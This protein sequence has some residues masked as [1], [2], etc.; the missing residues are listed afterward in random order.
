MQRKLSNGHADRVFLLLAMS[1]PLIGDELRLR[2]ARWVVAYEKKMG[3]RS[4]KEMAKELDIKP[5]Q[6]TNILNHER[7]YE[8]TGKIPT[9]GLDTFIRMHIAFNESMDRMVKQEPDELPDR[10]R[11]GEA[12]RE[13]QG[14]PAGA[15]MENAAPRRHKGHTP[16]GGT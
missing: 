15:S 2:L 6:L 1:G 4:R 7:L 9:I 8:E 16:G 10:H 12:P 11:R 13:R 5:P 3:Y 14:T